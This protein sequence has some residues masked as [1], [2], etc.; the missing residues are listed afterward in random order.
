MLLKPCHILS[1]GQS[2]RGSVCTV[3]LNSNKVLQ[4]IFQNTGSPS[5]LLQQRLRGKSPLSSSNNFKVYFWN[6]RFFP[7]L[8]SKS[9]MAFCEGRNSWLSEMHLKSPWGLVPPWPPKVFNF[10]YL[11]F[12]VGFIGSWGAWGLRE[13]ALS[14]IIKYLRNAAFYSLPR[15]Y[16]ETFKLS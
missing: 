1:M 13:V 5:P 8:N 14:E 3:L 9:F 11:R 4:N 6:R 2:H 12:L 15:D 10:V 16:W 7:P